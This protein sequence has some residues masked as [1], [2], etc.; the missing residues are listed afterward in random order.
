MKLSTRARYGL[1]MMVELARELKT[2]NLVRLGK[3]A[4]I[5][6]LSENYLAQ[7][8]IPLKGEGLLVGVSGKYGGYRLSK[9]ADKIYVSDVLDAVIGKINLVECAADPSICLNSSFCET[10]LIWV[11]LKESIS[12]ILKKYTL[13]D[14]IDK[15]YH[16]KM[17]NFY[18]GIKL[19]HPDEVM[20]GMDDDVTSGCPVQIK[21]RKKNKY[22]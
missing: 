14:L 22:N 15:G 5:T 11:L 18:P 9:S 21:P 16:Q 4:Q 6:G 20:A 19:L 3:I 8:A 2:E 1:R 12:D 13:A 17:R 7:L 10:R